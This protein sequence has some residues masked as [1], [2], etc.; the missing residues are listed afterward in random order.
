MIHVAVVSDE[1]DT[2]G[3]VRRVCGPFARDRGPDL[4]FRSYENSYVFLQEA[5]NRKRLFEIVFLDTS[6]RGMNALDTAAALRK[7]AEAPVLVF[8]SATEGYCMDAFRAGAVHYL[9]TPLAEKDVVEALERGFAFLERDWHRKVVFKTADDLAVVDLSTLEAVVSDDHQQLFC[10]ADGRQLE[11]RARISEV[12]ERLSD[13]SPFVFLSPCRG[14]L[15]NS[16]AVLQLTP[17]QV[18]LRSG[19][20]L[21]VAKR[22]YTEFKEAL[23]HVKSLLL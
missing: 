13:V 8:L 22:K 6:V 9:K 12:K 23:T 10:L 3:M 5:E 17:A 21:P 7:M 4:S 20:T 15:V 2:M 11:V 14:I 18:V 1:P 16:E 19:R